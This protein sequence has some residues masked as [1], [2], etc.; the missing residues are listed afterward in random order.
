MHDLIIHPDL[1]G[2]GLGSRLLR[3]LTQQIADD[4]VYD[5]GTVTPSSLMPFFRSSSFELD[6]EDSVPMAL[7]RSAWLEEDV[8]VVQQF[9]VANNPRLA[10]LLKQASL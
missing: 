8:E 3:R 4:G 7:R 1:Q 10:Q 6:R 2:F 5:V 9:G